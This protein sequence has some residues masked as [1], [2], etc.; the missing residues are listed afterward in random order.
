MQPRKAILSDFLNADFPIVAIAA[1][2]GGLKA[3]SEILSVLPADFPAAIT[4]V[5]HLSAQYPSYMAEILTR[6]TALRVKPAEDGERLR[7][8]TVYTPIPDKHLLIKADRT[9]CLSDEPKMNF[10]R[11]AA[12]KMFASV[13]TSF[14]ARAIAVVL[15]GKKTDGALGVVTIKKQGGLVIA[16]DEASCEYFSMPKAAIATGKVDLILPLNAIAGTL[17][18]LVNANKVA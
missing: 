2:Q 4:I 17:L 9:L 10:V 13:A 1:S 18:N 3:I 5:Q 6:R 12:N 16:Q 7:P 14:K 11:P 8:G 15:T